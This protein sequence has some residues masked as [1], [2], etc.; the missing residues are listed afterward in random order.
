[1]SDQSS[2]L[3]STL[4]TILGYLGGEVAEEVLFERLLWPERFYNDF[5]TSI[6]V[7]HG[8]LFPMGGPLHA[9]ALETLDILRK[10]GMY[11][12]SRRGDFLGTAFY[13]DLK[14]GYECAGKADD[15]RNGFWVRVSRC[16]SRA[17]L[18]NN[19][20]LP[21]FD[22]EDNQDEHALRLRSLQT[23]NYLT[24][25]LRKQVNQ[26]GT[27][28]S[29]EVI[30]IQEGRA[31][32]RT[33]SGILVSETV[34]LA[35]AIIAIFIGGWWVAIYM[36]IPLCLKIAALAA[37]VHREGL[38]SL[39][40]LENQGP[41]TTHET[42]RISDPSHGYLVIT[43]PRPVVTQF[44]RHYGHPTRFKSLGRYREVLSIVIIYSFVL[45]FPVGLVANIWMDSSIQYLWLAYQLYTVLAMHIIRLLG[46]QDCGRTEERV[47][48]ELML[49][50][51][52]RLQ[53]QYGEDVE[54]S[55]WTTFVPNVTSGE[56]TVKLLMRE[57][58][59]SE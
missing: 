27:D 28:K 47:A 51:T 45:Y 50:K 16:V 1:M 25:R 30:A 58:A 43:G 24:I 9:A 36:V 53:S 48:R 37:S 19:K 17:S 12:G 15:V 33:A 22:V 55:L 59:G 32:W 31:T 41:L 40:Q 6:L 20:D 18:S 38:E 56:E 5:S 11:Y 3:S 54:A 49:G 57:Q 44:F 21:K 26:P 35:T 23:V 46:W 14:L 29:P 7:K 10:Q 34:T 4:G 52:V 42:F 8:L 2:V 13:N 39:S